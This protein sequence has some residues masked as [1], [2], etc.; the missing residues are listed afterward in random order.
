MG[1]LNTFIVRLKQLLSAKIIP[2]TCT[3]IS[4]SFYLVSASWSRRILAAA[5][6]SLHLAPPCTCQDNF[7]SDNDETVSHTEYRRRLVT[8]MKSLKPFLPRDPCRR[9]SYLEKTLRTCT[10]VFV[11]DDGSATSLQPAYTGP[12]PVLDK[13]DKYFS[14]D[15][16]DRTDSVSIDRLKAAHMY[17]CRST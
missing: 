11:R 16:E 2:L 5:L 17:I 6:L 15:L 12:F 4:T 3:K 7:F 8:F 13:E 9:S 14:L 1:W 10:H